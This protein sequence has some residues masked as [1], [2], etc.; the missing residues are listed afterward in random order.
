MRI[1]PH[2]FHF[3][4]IPRFAG[5]SRELPLFS[6]P[7][8]ATNPTALRCS[9]AIIDSNTKDC[10][11]PFAFLPACVSIGRTKLGVPRCGVRQ[12][13]IQYLFLW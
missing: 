7:F 13:F 2:T 12:T 1:K 5:K 6:R 9:L 4:D 3:P 8:A 10:I 11:F